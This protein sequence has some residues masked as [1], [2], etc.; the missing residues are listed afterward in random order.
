M[1]Q[2]LALE[3]TRI[4][5]RI[6]PFLWDVGLSSITQI[7]VL[8][9]GVLIVSLFGRLLGAVALGQYLLLR[10]VAAWIQS[11]TQL[12]L[13]VALPRYVALSSHRGDSDRLAY[14]VAAALCLGGVAGAAS[15][16]LLLG[17]IELARLFF[18]TEQMSNLILPL[19]LLILGLTAHVAVY[20]YYRGCLLMGR[21]NALETINFA[22]A[23]IVSVIVLF[24]THS[25]GLIVCVMG[26]SMLISGIL[27]AMPR[28]AEL[29]HLKQ[30]PLRPFARELL[31]YGIARVP[32]E[33]AGGALFALGPVIA[34][35]YRP[36]SDV[37]RLLLGLS[38]LMALSVSVTPLGTVLLSKVSMMLARNRVEEVRIRLEELVAAVLELSVFGC[39]Q[40]IVFADV[41]VRAWVGSAYLA[42]L[43]VIQITLMSVPFYLYFVAI[44]SAIDAASVVA[45]NAHN[46]YLALAVFLAITFLAVKAAPSEFV[47]H[48]IAGALL[49]GNVVLAW[50]TTQVARNLFHMRIPW[51]E[52]LIPLVLAITLGSGSYAIHRWLLSQIGLVGL[53]GIETLMT[54][55]FLFASNAVGSMWLP[56]FLKLLFG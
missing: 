3:T 21:A 46:G 36:L 16:I 38:L 42:G 20:G 43:G 54:A 15:V 14:F 45:H 1:K 53:V 31:Q 50:R 47:L 11:G 32:G 10:R 24:R 22:L 19:A 35:H 44:R 7:L 49:A 39:L 12:G 25:V 27:F 6:H 51:K 17:R 30:P 33:F 34:S 9:C 48:S 28:F 23:P 41:L 29:L 2:E 5:R 8:A 18:G 26:L 56:S 4:G 55:V 40:M 37:S 13:G 52:C